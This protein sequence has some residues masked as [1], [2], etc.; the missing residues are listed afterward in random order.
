MELLE[1]RL[2][3]GHAEACAGTIDDRPEDGTFVFEGATGREMELDHEGADHGPSMP[4][5]PPG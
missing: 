1:G 2:G 4:E 5:T 3:D